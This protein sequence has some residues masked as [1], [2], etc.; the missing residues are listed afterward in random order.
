MDTRIPAHLLRR[1]AGRTLGLAT[2]AT[3]VLGLSACGG[4]DGGGDD[5]S[6]EFCD[7]AESLSTAAEGI[8]D[9]SA[10]QVGDMFERLSALDPPAEIAE[11]WD[12]VLGSF[13]PDN[14]QA[15]PTG[16]PEELAAAGDTIERYMEEECGI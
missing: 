4:D 7:E 13:D 11:E 5:A 6:A 14:V 8:D 2:A 10:A 1:A 16:D 9:P 12:L 3:L 15:G